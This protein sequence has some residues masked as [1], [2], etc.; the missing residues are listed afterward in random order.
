[1][2]SLE[3][4]TLELLIS[5]KK[6]PPLVREFEHSIFCRDIALKRYRRPDSRSHREIRVFSSLSRRKYC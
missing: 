4:A 2:I 5:H 6:Y 1:M 3:L